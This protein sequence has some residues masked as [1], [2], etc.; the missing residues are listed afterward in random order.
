MVIYVTFHKFADGQ[1]KILATRAM[2]GT[3]GLVLDPGI[4]RSW[5]K[6]KLFVSPGASDMYQNLGFVCIL[7]V[8]ISI[9]HI[10]WETKIGP[11]LDVAKGSEK[12]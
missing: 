7:D 10:N 4:T 8:K 9:F 1:G 12:L 6:I 3:D 2:S 11:R 5:F